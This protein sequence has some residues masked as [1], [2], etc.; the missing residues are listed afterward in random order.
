MRAQQAALAPL[1]SAGRF[2][3]LGVDVFRG[4]A[5]F[6]SPHE[7]AVGDLKLRARNCIIATGSRAAIP[8]PIGSSHAP[9]FTN[10]TI[11]DELKEKPE[12]LIVVGGGPIGCELGQMFNRLGVKVTILHKGKRLLEKEDPIVSTVL[13]E[14]LEAEGV[15]VL[16]GAVIEEVQESGAGISLRSGGE[17]MSATALLVAAGRQPN[18][19]NL[20][21]QKAN[22]AFTAKEVTVDEHL[23]TTQPGIYAIGDIIGQLQ[24]T[25]VADYHARIARLSRSDRPGRSVRRRKRPQPAGVDLARNRSSRNRR[26]DDLR[27]AGWRKTR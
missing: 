2:E 1:D 16:T 10:E 3:S 25:H 7:I 12:S 24:F 18:V 15:R 26:D 8:A 14:M 11:F 4:E 23:E 22:V 13:A 20:N 21:L 19:E 17:K 6:L 27:S 5:S 9:Y